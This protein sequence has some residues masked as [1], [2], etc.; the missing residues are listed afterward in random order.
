MKK[1]MM[2]VMMI[3]MM[4]QNKLQP[5]SNLKAFHVNDKP[6]L[7]DSFDIQH[8]FSSIQVAFLLAFI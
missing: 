5:F 8:Y 7:R 2:I 6:S 1:M 4:K 3:Q